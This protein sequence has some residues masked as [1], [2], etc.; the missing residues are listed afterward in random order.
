[1]IRNLKALGLAVM[2]AFALSAVGATAAQALTA[3]VGAGG[4]TIT[5][6]N[7]KIDP[8]HEDHTFTLDSG[9]MFTCNFVTFDGTIE[10]G[11]KEVIVTPTYEDC[12]SN[13]TQPTTV[14]HNG[15]NYRFYGGEEENGNPHLFNKVTVDLDCPTGKEIEVHV[16]SSAANHVT[17]STPICT[18]NV[19]EFVG[20]HNNT[21]ENTTTGTHDVDVTTTVEGIAVTRVHGSALVC[22]SSTQFAVYTGATTLRAY[23]DTAHTKQVSLTVTK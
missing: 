10:N 16:W 1:M 12:F 19:H 8:N 11:A 15:C 22:G 4:Q 23:S 18:Y 20:K 14:T 9:R 13:K 5:G 7:L 17:A 21:L 2:A 6:T 3:D